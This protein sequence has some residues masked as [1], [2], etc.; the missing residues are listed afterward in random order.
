MAGGRRG[1]ERCQSAVCVCDS[2][3]GQRKEEKGKVSDHSENLKKILARLTGHSEA[4]VTSARSS[5]LACLNLPTLLSHALAAACGK[6]DLSTNLGI[7][8]RT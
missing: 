6:H 2:C 4:R 8:F 5:H 7:D 1:Q 3:E